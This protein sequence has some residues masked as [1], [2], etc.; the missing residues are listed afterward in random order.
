MT[1]IPEVLSQIDSKNS[2]TSS[3]SSFT[4]SSSSTIGYNSIIVNIVSNYNSNPLGLQIQFSTDGS[5][6]ITYYSETYL[7]SNSY[8]K[9]FPI[10]D[11]YYRIIY[12]STNNPFTIFTRL[13][14][15]NFI[16]KQN[17]VNAFVNNIENS[18][19]AF[20]KLRVTNP[21]TLLDLKT[22]PGP[23]GST[24]FLQNYLQICNNFIGTTG[25]TGSK[26]SNYSETTI[27]VS[28]NGTYTNQSLKYC[29]YQPGKS[30]LITATGILDPNNAN[31]SGAKSRI[32]YFDNNSGLYFEYTANQCNI[33]LLNKGIIVT[34]TPQ[35]N[36]NIDT[37]NGNGNSGV[38]IN[39]SNAQIFVIDL[40]WL[41]SGRIRFGFF[42]YGKIQYCHEI[43][44]VNF[45][46]APYISNINLPI[47]Y[48][49]I[50]TAGA[51]CS[52]VQ[53]CSSIV[54]E[55]GYNPVGRPFSISASNISA[56]TTIS[57]ELGII[58]IRGGGTNYYHQQII[59]QNVTIAS[60]AVNDVFIYR[61]RL[62]LPSASSGITTG[63]YSINSS[64]SVTQG[65]TSGLSGITGG[66]GNSIII[67]E[68]TAS[69]RGSATFGNLNQVFNDVCQL[70][71]DYNNNSSILL[72]T[73]EGS[74]GGSSKVY[75]S[76]NWLE[77]Y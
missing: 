40:E 55:G 33:V 18:I 73:V 68:Q 28:E 2:V 62:Y 31:P 7:S 47:R 29:T 67:D 63:W 12:S 27:N 52:M 15:D 66:I 57:T 26:I 10:L 5:S 32:G 42:L 17:S 9:S 23:T 30:F 41:G 38:N 19:D 70:Y 46:T 59:P 13:S 43:T 44:N 48:E 21:Q 71:G 51:T 76:I 39:F 60:S 54:S 77:V 56:P 37:M 35:I 36:W 4:G 75:A 3:S 50:G 45:L 16:Y 22:P 64:Y 8:T 74:F 69:G 25:A 6:F 24:A 34:S 11:N 53:I 49:L 72:L 65:N 20:G 58:A 14:T 1:F 61:L